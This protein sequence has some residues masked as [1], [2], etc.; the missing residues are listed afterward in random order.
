MFRM[1][2]ATDNAAFVDAPGEELASI[3]ADLAED[4]HEGLG[5]APD[6]HLSGILR[7]TNG[8]NVGTWQ[9]TAE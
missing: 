5:Y 3:L 1:E 4:I 7:D 8:N 6:G 9:Y 2:I